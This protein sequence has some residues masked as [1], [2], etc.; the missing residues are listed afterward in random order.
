[1]VFGGLSVGVD[2]GM[3]AI[4]VP[5]AV[6]ALALTLVVESLV[7]VALT[8]CVQQQ[9]WSALRAQA[10]INL[11]THTVA[12]LL[13]GNWACSWWTVEGLVCATESFAL[14]GVLGWSMPRALVVALGCN[15]A[16]ALL[17]WCV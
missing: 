5:A 2:A 13:I 10:L 8:T 6:A 9:L 3:L 17:S 16:T 7:L 14:A 4:E 15:G 11:V 12:V 1:M